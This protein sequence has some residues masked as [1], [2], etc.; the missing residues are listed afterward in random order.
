MTERE[1]WEYQCRFI[2]ANIESKGASEYLHARWPNWKV[3]QHT[4]QTMDPELN[5]LGRDG[6]EL[7]QITPVVALANGDVQLTGN[8]ASAKTN[9][10]F[11]VFKRKKQA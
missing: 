11:A 4:P 5:N 9:V 3:P 10:Y 2:E 6:W 7:I 8:E 1:A